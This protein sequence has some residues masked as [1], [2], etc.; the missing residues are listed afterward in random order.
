MRRKYMITIRL[1][2]DFRED[3]QYIELL[4]TYILLLS[5]TGGQ[6]IAEA[7][8]GY[9]LWNEAGEYWQIGNANDWHLIP[10]ETLGQFTVS[11]RYGEPRADNET[12]LQD[13]VTKLKWLGTIE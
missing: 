8:R 5:G 10:R 6:P 12:P 13:L 7:R 11:Y 9:S 3:P 1:T 4:A 2:K